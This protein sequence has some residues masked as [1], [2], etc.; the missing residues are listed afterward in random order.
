[1]HS[2]SIPAEISSYRAGRVVNTSLEKGR[3]TI[4]LKDLKS[5]FSKT[6]LLK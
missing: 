5:G 3:S 6:V 4:N 2:Y 1:M